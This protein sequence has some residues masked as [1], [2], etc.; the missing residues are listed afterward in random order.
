ME[1][2]RADGPG[3]PGTMNPQPQPLEPVDWT[4]GTGVRDRRTQSPGRRRAEEFRQGG[5]EANDPI[6]PSAPLGE[7]P[8]WHPERGSAFL[9]RL[10]EK[11]LHT[12]GR[13]WEFRRMRVGK[14]GVGGEGLRLIIGPPRRGCTL[15]ISET[16]GH[17]RSICQMEGRRTPFTRD[18]DG[19]APQIPGGFWIGTMAMGPGPRPRRAFLPL[20]YRGERRCLMR[21]VVPNATCISP[22]GGRIACALRYAGEGIHKSARC[23]GC[24]RDDQTS[25]LTR[26]RASIPTARWSDATGNLVGSCPCFSLPIASPC[27][28][29]RAGSHRLRDPGEPG[30]PA[31]ASGWPR[32]VRHSHV[33]ILAGHYNGCQKPGVHSHPADTSPYVIPAPRAL[34]CETPR[35]LLTTSHP[36]RGSDRP[37]QPYW[38]LHGVR[39]K[40]A[41]LLLLFP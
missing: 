6:N 5:P 27:I 32:S 26:P 24:R 37:G 13:H 39:H 28:R 22:D 2:V 11:R 19:V 29:R 3:K 38:Q 34:H 18:H 16:G 31:L 35:I 15:F 23:R 14:S 36:S 17:W 40:D 1:I 7:G 30:E 41:R 9:V 33:V 12:T 25:S 10:L 8:I 4:T 20:F 21:I